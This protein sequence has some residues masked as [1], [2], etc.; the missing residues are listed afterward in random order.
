VSRP[1]A[2]HRKIIGRG[3]ADQTDH[4]RFLFA[5]SDAPDE[6]DFQHHDI[7]GPIVAVV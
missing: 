2:G 7:A 1:I 5:P 4:R 3:G 6:P